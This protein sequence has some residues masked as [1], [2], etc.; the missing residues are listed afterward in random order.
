[1]H[2]LTLW[3][4]LR[5]G[6]K[7]F[8]GFAKIEMTGMLLS[9]LSIIAITQLYGGQ[10]IGVLIAFMG[11]PALI[12]LAML[13]RIRKLL[14]D[15]GPAEDRIISHGAQS[16]LYVSLSTIS[17]YFDKLLLFF[18]LPPSSLALFVAADRFADLLRTGVQDVATA[19][20]PKFAESDNY[21]AR[22]HKFFKIFYVIFGI[23]LMIFAF[24]LLPWIIVLIYG[25]AYK[26]AI[27]YAQALVFSVALGNLA[28]MQFRY[29]RSK[30]DTNNF[31]NIM[32]G[33]SLFR[34]VLS[35]ALIP[36]LGLQGAVLSAILYRIILS[37]SIN[38]V[39]Q[40][41]YRNPRTNVSG[42]Q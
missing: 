23:I 40:K 19:L 34:I 18:F 10:Y 14:T 21:S 9:Q 31:R 39:I 32:V 33:T 13:W 2:G 30:L 29:I 8:S 11:F 20:A 17:I 42:S 27:P 35:V 3:R 26:G 7:N 28:S 41:D 5:I 24:T 36:T 38:Y 1:M 6:E 12:N 16:S 25:E 15:T 4:G 37:G 22:L